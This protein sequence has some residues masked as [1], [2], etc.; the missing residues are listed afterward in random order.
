MTAP[1][2]LFIIKPDDSLIGL[3]ET[4]YDSEDFLQKLLAR[5]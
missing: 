5:Y 1:T 2:G 4:K 3:S